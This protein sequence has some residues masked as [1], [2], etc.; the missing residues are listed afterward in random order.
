MKNLTLNSSLH[1]L[2][3]VLLLSAMSLSLLFSGSRV[4]AQTQRASENSL[5]LNNQSESPLAKYAVNLTE[6]SF[7]FQDDQKAAK[8]F[9]SELKEIPGALVSKQP[10]NPIIVSE[11]SGSSALQIVQTLAGKIAASE[12]SKPFRNKQIYWLDTSSLYTMSVLANGDNTAC[13]KP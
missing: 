7:N 11:D 2:T 4:F 13:M 8:G 9:D 6:T 1:R 5:N 12:P 3:A 10:V